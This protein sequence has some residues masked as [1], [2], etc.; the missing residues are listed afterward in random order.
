MLMKNCNFFDFTPN[1]YLKLL[2]ADNFGGGPF[3]VVGSVHLHT[4]NIPKA[5]NE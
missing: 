1:K 5:T 4:L 3:K 2:S